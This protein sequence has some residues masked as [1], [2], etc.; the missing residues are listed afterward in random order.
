[1]KGFTALRSNEIKIETNPGFILQ[2]SKFAS[3]AFNLHSPWDK[4]HHSF[5]CWKTAFL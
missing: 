1:V 3:S 5:C 2:N 4:E